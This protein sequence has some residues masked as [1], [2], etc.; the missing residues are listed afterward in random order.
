MRFD[1]I[2]TLVVCGLVTSGCVRA[3]VND[4]W[5]HNFRTIVVEEACADRSQTQHMANLFDMDM[6]FADVESIA[7]VIAEVESRFGKSLKKGHAG[8]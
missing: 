3:T 4:A 7:T 2:D 1:G 5:G 8:G 6:K